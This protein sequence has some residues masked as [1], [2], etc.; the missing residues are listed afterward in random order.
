MQGCALLLE[1]SIHDREN[2]T[3]LSLDNKNLMPLTSW[4]LRLHKGFSK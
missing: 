1:I 3:I 2:G 4:P